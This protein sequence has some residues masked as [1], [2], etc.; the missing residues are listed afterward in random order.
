MEENESKT[1]VVKIGTEVLANGETSNII[2]LLAQDAAEL[3]KGGYKIIIVTSGAVGK[4]EKKLPGDF[5]VAAFG[6]LNPDIVRRQ[7]LAAIGQG[8][9]IAEYETVFARYGL[10]VAQVLLTQGDLAGQRKFLNVC[11]VIQT[12]LLNGIIPILNENDAISNEELYKETKQGIIF[13]DNDG[14]A[15]SVAI[16]LQ[17]DG[18]V[19]VTDVKGVY[20]NYPPQQ[21]EQPIAILRNIPSAL[22]KASGTSEKGRGGMKSKVEAGMAANSCGIPAYIVGWEPRVLSSL[23]LDNKLVGTFLPPLPQRKGQIVI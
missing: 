15:R 11:A 12:L 17:L 5:P 6:G 19:F 14:L 8:S 7:V 4:G 23:L 2:S 21:D 16:K 20:Q 13:S 9:L 1:I 3:L 18:L 22:Y 10:I